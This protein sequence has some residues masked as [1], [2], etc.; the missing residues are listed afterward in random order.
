MKD[1]PEIT[2]NYEQVAKYL[3]AESSPAESQALETWL[4]ESPANQA[5]FDRLLALWMAAQPRVKVNTAAAWQKVNARTRVQATRPSWFRRYRLP[6]AAASLALLA[7]AALLFNPGVEQKMLATKTGDQTRV[8]TLSDGTTV[9]LNKNSELLYPEAFA[10]DQRQ[11]TLKGE[12]FFAVHRDEKAPF[13]ILAEGAE[14]TVLG[15]EFNVKT[16]TEQVE[17]LVE[18]GKVSLAAHEEKAQPVILEAGEKGQ[19]DRKTRAVVE[20]ETDNL[21]ALYWRTGRLEFRDESLNQV[22]PELEALFAVK[23]SLEKPELGNCLLTGTYEER[24]IES[25]LTGITQTFNLQ[26]TETDENLYLISGE[27]C[28]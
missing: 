15:T 28:H 22:I 7:L 11:V 25:V 5:E 10:A 1:N 13:T 9:T 23:I 16:G 17:V 26:L 20:S 6:L 8:V 4:A 24:E 18:S 14:V 19:F 2:V 27:G 3:S 21:N 12:A